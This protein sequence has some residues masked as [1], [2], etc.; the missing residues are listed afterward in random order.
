[1]TCTCHLPID[2]LI[3]HVIDG[4]GR[5]SSEPN[6]ERSPDERSQR[7]KPWNRKEHSHD[8]CERNQ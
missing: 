4:G 2:A 7:W 5:G 3:N 6:A 1:M 8:G